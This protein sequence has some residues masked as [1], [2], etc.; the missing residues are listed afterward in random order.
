MRRQAARSDQ[1]RLLAFSLQ[2]MIIPVDQSL[3]ILDAMEARS[4]R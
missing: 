2:Q 3:L 4:D 1:V